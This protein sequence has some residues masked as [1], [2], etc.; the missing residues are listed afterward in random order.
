MLDEHY[1]IA[2][3][4]HGITVKEPKKAKEYIKGHLALSL[5]DTRDVNSF[6]GENEL[7]LGKIETPDE[8]FAGIDKVTIADIVRRAKELFVPERVNLAIIGPFREQAVF[9]KIIG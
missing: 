1:K 7:M 5:E 4:K 8:V 2:G 3:G 9:E 6:Y